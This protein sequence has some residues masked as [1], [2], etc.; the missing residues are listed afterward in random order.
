LTQE[1]IIAL[2]EA[3]KQKGTVVLY[4]ASIECSSIRADFDDAFQIA[5]W[6]S[7]FESGP[8]E[9]ESDVGLF[10]GPPGTEADALIASIFKATGIK[11]SPVDIPLNKG[12]GIIFGKRPK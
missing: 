8:V 5:E 2:G 11:A 9:S 12:L 4:C 1:Q 10:V 7:S 6:D 3:L